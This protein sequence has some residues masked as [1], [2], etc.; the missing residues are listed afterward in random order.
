[1]SDSHHDSIS[2][3]KAAAVSYIF[4]ILEKYSEDFFKVDTTSSSI[5]KSKAIKTDI[6]PFMDIPILTTPSSA[7]AASPVYSSAIRGEKIKNSV[8]ENWMK[9]LREIEEYIRQILASPMYQQLQEIRLG[10]EDHKSNHIAGVQ[11]IS[12]SNS[13]K[14]QQIE[15]LSTLDR[16]QVLEKVPS[17]VEVQMEG[18]S[19]DASRSLVMPLTAALLMGGG[20]A[21]GTEF[22]Y[23][24]HSVEGY[25][26]LV[27]NL[28][29]LFSSLAVQDLVP[30][31]NFMIVGPIY[32]NSWN[33]AVSKIKHLKRENRVSVVQNF[34]KD[35]MSIVS[36]PNLVNRLL[37]HCMRG[38]KPLSHEEQEN[39]GRMFKIVLIGVSLSLLYSAEV[40]KIQNG[41]FGG[42]E[43]EELRELL[44]GRF[45]KPSIDND[46]MSLQEELTFSLIKRIWE[47]LQPLSLKNRIT[48]ID[49]LMS[50]ITQHRDFDSMVDPAK[51]FEEILDASQFDP[52]DKIGECLKFNLY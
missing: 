3:E 17:N 25:V 5:G 23:P 49:I 39:L 28:Q 19:Q 7:I 50:Y 4:P 31:I 12:S 33:E 18:G 46:K 52:K 26:G 13:A 36:D 8:I 41:R 42:I 45:L 40:G 16:L 47:Q 34:A 32:F 15:L 10:K 24:T 44:M 21:I 48:A 38:K 1:M 22:V 20:L 29:P 14:N 43:P 9:N 51:V 11:E 2:I 27:E 35:V 30:L 37:T 6:V